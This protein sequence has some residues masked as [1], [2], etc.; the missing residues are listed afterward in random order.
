MNVHALLDAVIAKA[1]SGLAG[2]RTSAQVVAG[3]AR[4]AEATDAAAARRGPGALKRG[5]Y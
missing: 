1:V 2:T 5:R 4:D 3:Y